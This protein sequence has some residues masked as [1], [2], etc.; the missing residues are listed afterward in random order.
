MHEICECRKRK[1]AFVPWRQPV[2][3]ELHF[4]QKVFRVKYAFLSGETSKPCASETGSGAARDG[5]IEAGG[6]SRGYSTSQAS[7]GRPEPVG[8]SSTVGPHSATKTPYGRVEEME[9]SDG[10]HGDAQAIGPAVHLSDGV[11][12]ASYS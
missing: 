10:K 12:V 2:P 4:E 11:L 9:D 1:R 8:R 7:E 3:F 6:V 5:G